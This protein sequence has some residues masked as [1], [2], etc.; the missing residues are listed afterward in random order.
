MEKQLILT[1]MYGMFLYVPSNF[2]VETKSF[3]WWVVTTLDNS[4]PE[5]LAFV[6]RLFLLLLFTCCWIECESNAL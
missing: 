3:Q 6:I 2:L 5:K 4:V 1:A